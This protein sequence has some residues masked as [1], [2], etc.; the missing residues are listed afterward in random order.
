[1]NK[2]KLNV[3]YPRD[4]LS[5]GYI[6]TDYE[7]PKAERRPEEEDVGLACLVFGASIGLVAGILLTILV[8]QF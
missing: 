5:G 7:V 6:P 4:N 2:N 1:M 8:L 3:D